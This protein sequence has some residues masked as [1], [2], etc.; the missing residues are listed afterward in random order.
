MSPTRT[1][2]WHGHNHVQITCNTSS[3]YHA[4]HVTLHAI[5]YYGTAQL[6]RL[7]EFK[8]YLFELLFI[9]WTINWWRRGGNWSTRRKPLATSFRNNSTAVKADPSLNYTSMLL[10]C[11]ATKQQ[12]KNPC[13]PCE[14]KFSMSQFSPKNHCALLWRNNLESPPLCNTFNWS[15]VFLFISR[16]T[17]QFRS[18]SSPSLHL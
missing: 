8:S 12:Q 14:S 10:Q 9:D 2:K 6:L 7:T 13:D 17:W 18:L 5:W 3:A 1:L 11:S 4:Q 15:P 16:L